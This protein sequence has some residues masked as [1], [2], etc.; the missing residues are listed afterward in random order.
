MPLIG[1]KPLTC[2][3]NYVKITVAKINNSISQLARIGE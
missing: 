1:D 2:F 3:E